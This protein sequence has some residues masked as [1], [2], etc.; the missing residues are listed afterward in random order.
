MFQ[1]GK[2]LCGNGRMICSRVGLQCQEAPPPVEKV[3]ASWQHQHGISDQ[4]AIGKLPNDDPQ[5]FGI[6][7]E[8]QRKWFELSYNYNPNIFIYYI[9]YRFLKKNIY[10]YRWLLYAIVH[11]CASHLEADPGWW[12]RFCDR[13]VDP[14]NYRCYRQPKEFPFHPQKAEIVF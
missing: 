3:V 14:E 11:G 4:T 2:D 8:F 13:K 10:I 12:I 9:I 7:K 5:C 6:R 1:H